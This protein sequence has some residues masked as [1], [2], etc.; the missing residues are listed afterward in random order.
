M[1]INQSNKLATLLTQTMEDEVIER[2]STEGVR[3]KDARGGIQEHGNPK[4][5]DV[6]HVG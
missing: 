3:R 6:N 2:N 4:L 5:D 1:Q